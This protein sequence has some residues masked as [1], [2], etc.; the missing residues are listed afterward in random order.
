M[1][2]ASVLQILQHPERDVANVKIL[3]KDPQKERGKKPPSFNEFRKAREFSFLRYAGQH[4][5]I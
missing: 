4:V 2:C 5:F 1:I 3:L